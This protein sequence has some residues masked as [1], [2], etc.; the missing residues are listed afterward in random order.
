MSDLKSEA[1]IRVGVR[2]PSWAL[3]SVGVSMLA[4]RLPIF[5]A[6][7]IIAR[8]YYRMPSTTRLTILWQHFIGKKS[9]MDAVRQKM[10][11]QLTADKILDQIDTW[12]LEGH[13][14]GSDRRSMLAKLSNLSNLAPEF[15]HRGWQEELKERI[16]ERRGTNSKELQAVA[17]LPFPDR[18]RQV[19]QLKLG[20]SK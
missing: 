17:P 13:I 2:V 19:R 16:I 15:R 9:A 1:G 14:S 12:Y 3:Y 4:S 6:P 18:K 8:L 7:P 10:F 5:T 20:R 11:W